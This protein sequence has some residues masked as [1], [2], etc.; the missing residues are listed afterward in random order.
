MKK[1][2]LSV[3]LPAGHLARLRAATDST[4]NPYVTTVTKIVERGID[5]AL[6]EI[7]R[8]KKRR[9]ARSSQ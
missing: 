3:R 1:P 2:M 7:D 5:L 6:K 9:A 8:K 4:K